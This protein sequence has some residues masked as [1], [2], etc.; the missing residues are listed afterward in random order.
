MVYLHSRCF[1]MMTIVFIGVWCF[2][3][4]LSNYIFTCTCIE[5][6]QAAYVY[7]CMFSWSVIF[8]QYWYTKYIK[9]FLW[10][11]VFEYIYDLSIY[12]ISPYAHYCSH[13]VGQQSTSV[14]SSTG[15]YIH[16]N[17]LYRTLLHTF[18]YH[19][20]QLSDDTICKLFNL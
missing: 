13:C 12:L 1:I 15:I 14:T 9:F 2:F 3:A 18:L 11:I 20:F 17:I 16:I 6:I 5:Y 19:R 8:I 7:T 10:I 4:P